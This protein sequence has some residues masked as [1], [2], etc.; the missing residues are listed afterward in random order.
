MVSEV[1]VHHC[2][3][4]VTEQP[5]SREREGTQGPDKDVKVPLPMTSFLLL[6][7]ISKIFYG[8]PEIVPLSEVIKFMFRHKPVG[9]FMLKM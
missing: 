6:G 5:G 7:P 8:F 3:E 1:L 2:E 4:G 9:Y